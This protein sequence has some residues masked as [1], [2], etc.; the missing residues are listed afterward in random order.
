[1]RERHNE[2]ESV[3]MSVNARVRESEKETASLVLLGLFGR[4]FLLLLL[5]LPTEQVQ[6]LTRAEREPERAHLLP[7]HPPRHMLGLRRALALG[8]RDHLGGR[9]GPAWQR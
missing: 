8:G 6:R 3:C 2:S 7:A 4:G 5:L 9:G 1:M